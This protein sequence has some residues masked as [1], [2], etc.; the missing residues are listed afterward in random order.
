M[1]IAHVV[2]VFPPY[3]AGM[4]NSVYFSALQMGKLGHDSVIFTPAHRAADRGIAPLGSHVTVER[5]RP[6]FGIGNAAVLPQLAWRL[7][8]FDIV[9]VHY[10]FF[11]S[12]EIAL[13]GVLFG[14]GR[15]IM[16][17]HMD[18]VSR[19][20]KG[21][22]FRT[23]AFFFLPIIARLSRLITCASFDYV[24]HSELGAYYEKHKE[25]FV[26]V[27]F[28]VDC[29]RFTPRP[30]S[31]PPSALFVG[32]LDRQHYFK[33]VEPLIQ[34]FAEATADLPQARLTIVG[35][36]ELEPYYR[37]LI[38]LK[39]I[40]EKVEILNNVSD[41]EL[42]DCYRQATVAVLPSINKGEAFGL[43]LLEAMASGTP[44]IASNLPGVRNVFRNNEHGYLIR[45]GHVE[46]LT[47]KL[48]R[49][50]SDPLRAQ[51]MGEAA[52]E[53]IIEHYSWEKFNERLEAAYCRVLYT[54]E[55]ARRLSHTRAPD[56]YEDDL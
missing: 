3:K 22:I 36:G 30:K 10:P 39:G 19:G 27:P 12:A 49:V 48:R 47:E 4:G 6:L 31:G 8:G 9:H 50:L 5:L 52:R 45:P 18:A 37:S 44:V 55:E 23:Y 40:T 54:P 46:D 20:L 25:K 42:V 56:N 26:Q 29:Q 41:E 32:G 35:K 17:Y 53:W 51:Q 33:G 43:V 7:K 11:G 13:L 2:C 16:H 34:A 1:K 24:K 28:G 38:A 21:L 14:K 15:L